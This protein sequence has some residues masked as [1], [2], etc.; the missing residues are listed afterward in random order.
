MQRSDRSPQSPSTAL[1]RGV[2]RALLDWFRRHARD[3]PWR[4][5][6]DPYAIYV[7]EIMLQQTQ[8]KTVIPYW[9]RWM[10]ALP[11][12]ES[13]A[14]AREPRVLR[15]WEGLGYYRRAR[16]LHAAA[17][18]L[19]RERR[20]HFPTAFDEVL[21][22]P[23]VGRYTAGAIC[24]IAYNQRTPLLDGNATRVL[25]RLFGLGGNPKSQKN[26]RRLWS[27]ADRLVRAAADEPSR[28]RRNCGDLNQALMDLGATSC[29]PRDPR[30]FDCPLK[31]RCQ[32]FRTA[33]QTR[34]PGPKQGSQ[35]T[36]QHVLAVVVER[37][38]RFLIRQRP[39]G[40]VN[41]GLWEFPNR[42]ITTGRNAVQ[43]AIRQITGEA[44]PKCE[45]L[46]RVRHSITRYRIILD[47]YR[48]TAADGAIG[49]DNVGRIPPPNPP[50]VKA[51]KSERL[52]WCSLDQLRRLPFPSAHR[53]IVDHLQH[54][55]R[56]RPV[57]SE[58]R[59]H[60]R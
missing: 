9:Q 60:S 13:L 25:T 54:T 57:A 41:G 58:P 30:C 38:G 24:S 28:G 14:R 12:L 59:H 21:A 29:T 55:A 44:N 56:L 18:A 4:R 15:L 31:Q 49:F 22:L 35:P 39:G 26:D 51:G 7:S 5:T 1:T 45:R 50:S 37:Q 33:A 53:R 48:L 47:A 19:V 8:V 42:E 6:H 23:G 20:G 34:V 2:A 17:K 46:L 40:A 43:R 11:T 52:R 32:A 16:N 27:W 10:R 3:L 36:L